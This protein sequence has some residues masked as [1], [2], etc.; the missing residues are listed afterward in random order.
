MVLCLLLLKQ[1]SLSIAPPN[2]VP[3]S[4]DYL[5]EVGAVINYGVSLES[6]VDGE[7]GLFEIGAE[8]HGGILG[9]VVSVDQHSNTVIQPDLYSGGSIPS[10]LMRVE[11]NLIHW[12]FVWG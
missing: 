2:V 7:S 1:V 5:V 11:L 10:I 9:T 4:L 8:T 12:P 3:Q 6:D